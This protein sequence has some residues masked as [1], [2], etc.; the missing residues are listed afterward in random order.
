MNI[1]EVLESGGFE[2]AKKQMASQDKVRG[3]PG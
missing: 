2:L 3:E 1:A